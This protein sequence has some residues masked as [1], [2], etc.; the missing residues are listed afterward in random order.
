MPGGKARRNVNRLPMLSAFF[1][2]RTLYLR[3]GAGA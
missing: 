2:H 3:K 1:K